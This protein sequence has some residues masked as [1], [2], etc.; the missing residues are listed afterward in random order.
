MDN[1]EEEGCLL[2]GWM[3]DSFKCAKLYSFVATTRT[4]VPILEDHL[5]LKTVISVAVATQ[6]TVFND[7]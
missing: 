1:W 3:G 6:M 4:S 2:L 5:S 7:R